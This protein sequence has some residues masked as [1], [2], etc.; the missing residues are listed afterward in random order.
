[1]PRS[2]RRP[3]C[4]RGP[5]AAEAHLTTE[6]AGRDGCTARVRHAHALAKPGARE[7][8]VY[9]APYGS[10][11]R[12]LAPHLPVLQYGPGDTRT[13]HAPDESVP[14]EDFHAAARA[15][16]VIYLEHCGLA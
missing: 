1:M 13:A 2:R 11:L 7:Q 15:L 10:D 8:E 5:S 3:S 9:G 6:P 4:R 16:A 14:V 12:L